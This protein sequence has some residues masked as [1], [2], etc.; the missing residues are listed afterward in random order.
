M[1]ALP[2]DIG[3]VLLDLVPGLSLCV[4]PCPAKKQCTVPMPTRV[5]RSISRVWISTKVMSHRSAISPLMKSPVA[6][7]LPEWRSPPRGLANVLPC[8]MLSATHR[9]R[10][11]LE[12]LAP[13]C[14]AAA[15]QLMPPSIAATTLSRRS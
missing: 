15:R 14:A 7:I 9:P 4:I 1:L 2:Q 5:P 3:P 11:A 8:W 10:I 12:A 6:S 13:K